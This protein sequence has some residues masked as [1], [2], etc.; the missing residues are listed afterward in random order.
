MEN[1]EGTKE[2]LEYP[3]NSESRS[4]ECGMKDIRSPY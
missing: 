1:L 4:L 3:K 2:D